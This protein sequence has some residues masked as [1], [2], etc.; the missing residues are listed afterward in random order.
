M[1]AE[2]EVA[3]PARVR[4]VETTALTVSIVTTAVLGSVAV[5]GVVSAG[6]G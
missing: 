5:V 3:P 2:G 4:A 6:H 1:S